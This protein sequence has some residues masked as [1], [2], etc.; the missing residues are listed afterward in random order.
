[1]TIGNRIAA[2]A[3][4]LVGAPFRLRGRDPRTGIDCVG[5]ALIAFG[6]AGL[7]VEEPPGYALRG[8]SLA[9]AGAMLRAAGLVPAQGGAAGDLVLVEAGPMQLHFMIRA[10]ESACAGHAHAHAGLGRVVLMPGASPWPV[11]GVW[12]ADPSFIQARR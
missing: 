6:R 11:R 7:R 10:G 3:L 5:L 12:R 2:E 1:M 9:R 4:G 8:T